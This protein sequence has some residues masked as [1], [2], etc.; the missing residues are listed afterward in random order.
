LNELREFIVTHPVDVVICY[1]LDRLA[2]KTVYQLL[3]AEELTKRGVLVEYVLGNYETTPEGQLMKQIRASV[4]EYERAK[5]ME[6]MARGKKGRAQ[7]GQVTV[8]RIAPHGC[9]YVGEPHKG[10][11]VINEKEAE[12]V[13]LIFEWYVNGDESSHKLG[14]YQIARRLS[15]RRLPTKDDS[16]GY[17][18]RK[19]EYGVWGKSTVHRILT[20]EVYAGVWHWGRTRKTSKT[21]HTAAA[22]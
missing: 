18:K 16:A 17:T 10:Q 22:E 19:N 15:E 7:A 11:F 8:G 3:I 14:A 6:R 13:R 4:A 21:T 2:R 9:D 5:I 20:N 12:T 1:E